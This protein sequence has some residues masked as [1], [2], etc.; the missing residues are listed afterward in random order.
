MLVLVGEE[1]IDAFFK[2]FNN[3]M[4]RVLLPF[5][6]E[7][8]VRVFA[9]A[10]NDQVR[11]EPPRVIFTPIRPRRQPLLTIKVPIIVKVDGQ[12]VPPKILTEALLQIDAETMYERELMGLKDKEISILG[13]DVAERAGY[14][15]QDDRSVYEAFACHQAI[16]T[17]SARSGSEFAVSRAGGASSKPGM[18]AVGLQGR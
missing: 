5:D 6:D 8:V 13:H 3:G 14:S 7:D 1:P 16:A 11:P 4:T 9:T 2:R 15:L 10:M 18:V 17:S 12:F